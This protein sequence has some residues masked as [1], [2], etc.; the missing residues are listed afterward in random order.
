M[1]RRE[2]EISVVVPTLNN[3]AGTI[4]LV[5]HLNRVFVNRKITAEIL[6]IDDASSLINRTH[7]IAELQG[8]KI[9]ARIKLILLSTRCGQFVS[10]R[11]GISFSEGKFILTLDDDKFIS[12]QS[13][14]ILVEKIQDSNLDFI[15]GTNS[16][17][18]KE[19]ILVRD[20]ARMRGRRA[21][22]GP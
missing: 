18:K 11:Y 5:N 8:C 12:E 4:Q 16:S 14:M 22:G 9:T 19:N 7:L 15:V 21:C 6:L 17:E 20:D 1:Q 3:P 13:V 10:T 2:K